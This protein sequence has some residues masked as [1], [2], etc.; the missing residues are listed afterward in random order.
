[1]KLWLI[2][3]V[4]VVL[5]VVGYLYFYGSTPLLSTDN[6]EEDL[7]KCVE[8]LAETYWKCAKKAGDALRA[9]PIMVGPR[10]NYANWRAGMDKCNAARD[11]ALKICI[12]KFNACPNH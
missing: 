3:L 7:I 9:S 8:S 6:C 5:G 10:G 1:M 4:I 12:E 11:A 2:G